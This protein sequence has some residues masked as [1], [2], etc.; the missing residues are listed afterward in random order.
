MDERITN[1]NV[2]FQY[3]LFDALTVPDS[4]PLTPAQAPALLPATPS[5]AAVYL[6]SL[7]TGSRRT[8]LSALRQLAQLLGYPDYLACPWASLRYQHT[9][10]IR[11]QLQDAYAPATANRMLACLRRVLQEAW[12]LEL[13]T[14]E[15]YRRAADLKVIKAQRL[16]SGRALSASEVLR[17]FEVCAHDSTP[18]GVRDSALL[19]VLIG[20]GLRRAEAVAL[21][22]DDYDAGTGALK[23][24]S[25]KGRKDR[26]VYAA[27]GVVTALA[28]WLTVRGQ[29]SGAL[30][31]RAYKGGHISSVSMTDQAVRVILAKRAALAGV[32]DFSP[33]D[34]R[35]THI[36]SLL[37]AGADLATVQK[38]AGHADPNTT[39]RYDRRGEAAKQDAVARLD[40]PY[41]PRRTLP[42][43]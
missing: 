36:T 2:V 42:L 8:M 30:F 12:R 23:V 1:E 31:V 16:P 13:M 29:S 40:I 34:L 11:A 25:G 37:D 35:R 22:V 15:E 18:A 27:G 10:A 17:L 43:D 28:D 3:Q 14:A 24:R 4:A 6:A 7:T 20:C 38:L 41:L 19:A 32:A 21:D 26:I 39:A 9:A 33:H 5:P